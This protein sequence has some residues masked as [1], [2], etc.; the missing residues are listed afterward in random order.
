MD[1]DIFV[2]VL[3]VV[4]AI[5]AA[6][7]GGAVTIYGAGI[8]PFLKRRRRQL[9]GRWVGTASEIGTLDSSSDR[10]AQ[11]NV[12]FQLKQTRSRIVGTIDA[13][14]DD[15]N[16]FHDRLEG[17]LTTEQ[18]LCFTFAATDENVHDFGAAIFHIHPSGKEMAGYVLSNESSSP[19]ARVFVMRASMTR[20]I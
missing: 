15:G 16:V 6:L 13:S 17:R 19:S 20:S 18:D 10:L 11:Y 3:G 7:I 1:N 5:A 12:M 14:S 4:G 9:G 8:T 2:A